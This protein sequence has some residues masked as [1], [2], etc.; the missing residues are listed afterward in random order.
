MTNSR[1]RGMVLRSTARPIV[2][3]AE[4]AKYRPRLD[5]SPGLDRVG[6]PRSDRRRRGGLRHGRGLRGS[7]RPV[8]VLGLARLRLVVAFD[9]RAWSALVGP[10]SGLPPAATLLPRAGPRM[11]RARLPRMARAAPL[12]FVRCAL[13]GGALGARGPAHRGSQRPSAASTPCRRPRPRLVR[14]SHLRRG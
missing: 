14:A 1:I 9:R 11:A 2:G 8:P 10:A 7:R 5:A 12:A 4:T 6:A 3:D 13:G